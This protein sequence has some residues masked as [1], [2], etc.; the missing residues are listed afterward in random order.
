MGLAKMQM[1]KNNYTNTKD[2]NLTI[3]AC[4]PRLFLLVV[5]YETANF[6][7]IQNN[8]TDMLFELECKNCV[9]TSCCLC[10]CP[11]LKQVLSLSF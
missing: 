7:F 2:S 10:T 3:R 6:S 1:A 4:V 5:D 11:H 9:L 8:G